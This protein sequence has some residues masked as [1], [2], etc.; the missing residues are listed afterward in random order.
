MELVKKTLDFNVRRE[1]GKLVGRELLG[2]YH[3]AKEASAIERC[4]PFS[5]IAFPLFVLQQ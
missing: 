1:A 3:G 2:S 4:F 5:V